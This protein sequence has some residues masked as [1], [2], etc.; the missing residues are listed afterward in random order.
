LKFVKKREISSSKSWASTLVATTQPKRILIAED[1]EINVKLAR[2]I[3]EKAGHSVA[4]AENGAEAI[5][6]WEE[7]QG[8]DAF[9]LIFMDLQMPVKDG[10]GA[11]KEIR[12]IEQ[13]NDYPQLP[14][15]I[16]TADE[17][18]DTRDKALHLGATGFLTKP[19]EPEK[20]LT[21]ADSVPTKRS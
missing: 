11:L 17:K 9:D 19:L 8:D 3:L 18:A 20:L 14:I 13:K 16:L 4:R 21:A 7:H 12:D 5:S 10:L 15:F 6:L 1:N 2:G